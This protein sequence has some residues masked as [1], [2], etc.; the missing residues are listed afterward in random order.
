MWV[1]QCHKPTIWEL[2][3]YTTYIFMVMAG[4]WT[5][6]AIR[7]QNRRNKNPTIQGQATSQLMVNERPTLYT[8]K[9]FCDTVFCSACWITSWKIMENPVLVGGFSPP[10]WKMMEWV[11]VGMMKF[12]MHR[13]QNMFQSTNQYWNGYEYMLGSLLN[14]LDWLDGTAM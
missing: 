1:K 14:W 12:P 11:T 3:M 6:Q 8:P 4:G 10:L 7:S 2:F 9:S 13:K 5:Q